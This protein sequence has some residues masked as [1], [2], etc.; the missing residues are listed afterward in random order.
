MDYLKDN[1]SENIMK[2]KDK[3]NKYEEYKKFVISEKK[4]FSQVGIIKT[5]YDQICD[6][7]GN[8]HESSLKLSSY[9][10]RSLDCLKTGILL[11]YIKVIT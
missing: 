2:F 7:F 11:I 5:F 6:I 10:S 8:K 1:N 9:L 3:V 4:N